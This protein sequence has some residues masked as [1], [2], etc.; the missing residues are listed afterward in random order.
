MTPLPGNY[1]GSG[2]F[3]LLIAIGVLGIVFVAPTV[4]MVVRISY[5]ISHR[6][7]EQQQARERIRQ[8]AQYLFDSLKDEQIAKANQQLEK[9]IAE[10]NAGRWTEAHDLFRGF[11]GSRGNLYR[12]TSWRRSYCVQL[13]RLPKGS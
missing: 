9:G 11:D 10:F 7:K 13:G 3:W 6:A 4:I 12:T 2:E 5:M 1:V 8:E